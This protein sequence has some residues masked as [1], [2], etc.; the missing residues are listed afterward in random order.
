MTIA[1]NWNQEYILQHDYILIQFRWLLCVSS[2]FR[3]C[4]L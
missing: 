4:I 3:I 2:R 1:N